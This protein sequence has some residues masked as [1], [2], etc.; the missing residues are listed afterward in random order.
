MLAWFVRVLTHQQDSPAYQSARFPSG[1][2]WERRQIV[3]NGM[4]GLPVWEI[5]ESEH[6]VKP[7]LLVAGLQVKPRPA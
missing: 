6:Y 3:L 7:R 2:P 5:N 1:R 4:L